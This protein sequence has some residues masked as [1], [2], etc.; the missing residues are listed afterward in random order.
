M[1]SSTPPFPLPPPLFSFHSI[2]TGRRK[3][4]RCTDELS[5]IRAAAW[6]WYQHGSGSEKKLTRE[7]DITRIRKVYRPSRY[8]M[9][10]LAK[11]EHE[12]AVVCEG[13]ISEPLKFTQ[14]PAH[15]DHP[16]L[17][18]YEV[19]K[20]TGLLDH[21]I[22]SMGNTSDYHSSTV[23]RGHRHRRKLLS[24]SPESIAS[25]VRKIAHNRSVRFWWWRRQAVICGRRED[26]ID[27]WT[28]G[29]QEQK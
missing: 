1:R 9:E 8:R 19:Q 26:V 21:Y 4:R 18:S 12:H 2:L 29:V 24:A 16:L 20:I 17:D 5:L 10:A 28:R 23:A 11:E 25:S 15:T 22:D 7:C 27:D 6:A 14:S 3:A 13:S